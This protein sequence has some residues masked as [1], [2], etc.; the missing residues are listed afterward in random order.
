MISDYLEFA[1]ELLAK[2]VLV[3]SYFSAAEWPVHF[4]SLFLAAMI[5]VCSNVAQR[6]RIP[7]LQAAEPDLVANPLS[8][9]ARE[10][11][12]SSLSVT[13]PRAAKRQPTYIIAPSA[14]P[15]T[16]GL[17]YNLTPACI[18]TARARCWH[19]RVFLLNL[20]LQTCCPTL[21]RSGRVWNKCNIFSGIQFEMHFIERRLRK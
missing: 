12:T 8:L 15:Q 7:L 4:G 3:R 2:W 9:T 10:L 6:I 20:G 19:Q 13:G 5:Q 16:S 1:K 21:L 14:P 17:F 18:A 11:V